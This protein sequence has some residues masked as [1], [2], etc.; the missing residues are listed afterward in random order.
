MRDRIKRELERVRPEQLAKG[1]D[2]S[3][4]DNAELMAVCLVHGT[5]KPLDD[6]G[7]WAE[8]IAILTE[9][10]V[11]NQASALPTFRRVLR[12]LKNPPAV[13]PDR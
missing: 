1:A 11:T 7:A 6:P 4:F 2:W 3:G 9:L 10:W 13:V 5:G 8:A 12:A